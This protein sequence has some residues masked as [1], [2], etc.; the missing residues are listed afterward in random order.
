[1]IFLTISCEVSC[2][3]SC[4]NNLFLL[5]IICFYQVLFNSKTKKNP[6]KCTKCTNSRVLVMVRMTGLEPVSNTHLAGIFLKYV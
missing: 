2:E 3:V 4:K 6:A 1:M 5:K